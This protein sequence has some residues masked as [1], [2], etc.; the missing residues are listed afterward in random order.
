M[1]STILQYKQ[2]PFEHSASALMYQ[3][4]RLI[5]QTPMESD[6]RNIISTT[7]PLCLVPEGHERN[8]TKIENHSATDI[9]K[10]LL[11]TAT[12]LVEKKSE[13]QGYVDQLRGIVG[14]V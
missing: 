12:R 4:E 14:R 5:A 6:T 8:P 10:E 7:I 2:D 13:W 9:L 11:P 3:F 1:L